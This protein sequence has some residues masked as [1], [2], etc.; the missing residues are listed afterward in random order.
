[1]KGHVNVSVCERAQTRL[2]VV[3]T[4]LTHRLLLSALC[5]WEM[6]QTLTIYWVHQHR[7]IITPCAR[8]EQNRIRSGDTA[9]MFD[10]PL[11]ALITACSVSERHSHWMTNG[12]SCCRGASRGHTGPHGAGSER[13][14]GPGASASLLSRCKVNLFCRSVSSLN[15]RA[16]KN[17]CNEVEL[18]CEGRHV[19]ARLKGIQNVSL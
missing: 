2:V 5:C 8:P 6:T 14:T 11:P 17:I 9:G 10:A 15:T 1:M 3:E 4:T 18:W 19:T 16:V 7:A 12:V 13:H